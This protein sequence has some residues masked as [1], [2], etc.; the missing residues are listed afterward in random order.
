V[1]SAES[2][3]DSFYNMSRPE[4]KKISYLCFQEKKIVSKNC[5][6]LSFSQGENK[7]VSNFVFSL[8][9]SQGEFFL[10]FSNKIYLSGSKKNTVV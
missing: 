1:G 9:F 4:T 2:G 8:G 5:F 3:E 10:N 7:F 6:S